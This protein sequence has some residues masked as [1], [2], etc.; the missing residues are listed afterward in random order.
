MILDGIEHR[1][2]VRERN[3]SVA[4]VISQPGWAVASKTDFWYLSVEDL[5]PD[6]WRH[7]EGSTHFGGMKYDEAK[8]KAVDWYA[9]EAKKGVVVT[10]HDRRAAEAGNED[11]S[12]LPSEDPNHV[13]GM[14]CDGQD[15]WTS[16]CAK[17]RRQ[18]ERQG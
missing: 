4:I 8:A 10:K 14:H 3:N 12:K 6:G 11:R 5:T 15:G 13:C 7:R 9:R 2:H 18:V 1:F 16:N 17:R